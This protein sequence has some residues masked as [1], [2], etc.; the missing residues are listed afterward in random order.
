KKAEKRQGYS[1]I[2][3]ALCVGCRT[4]FE[5]CKFDAIKEAVS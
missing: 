1:T 5:V 4:C 2:N 3:E